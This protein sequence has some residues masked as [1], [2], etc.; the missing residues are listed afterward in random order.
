MV[1]ELKITN[2]QGRYQGLHFEMNR[3][4]IEMINA[5]CHREVRT[6]L[7]NDGAVHELRTNNFVGNALDEWAAND[8]EDVA[9]FRQK[10]SQQ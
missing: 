7:W 8:R 9:A 3:R 4:V 1:E 10:L 5:T 2:R 6:H